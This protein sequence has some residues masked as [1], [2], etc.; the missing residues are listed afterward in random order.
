MIENLHRLSPGCLQEQYDSHLRF[1]S[2]SHAL[3][4]LW[5]KDVSLWPES[6]E[7]SPTSPHNLDWLDLPAMLDGLLARVARAF[8]PATIG[9][10]DQIVF[11]GVHSAS[12]AAELIATVPMT[13]SRTV[14]LMN[15]VDPG[16]I[17]AMESKVDLSR[18]LF[19]VA[20]K[21][22][23]SLQVSLLLLHFLKRF[24]EAGMPFPGSHFM[25]FTES[26]SYLAELAKQY[27][28]RE[29]FV[30]PPGIPTQFSGLIHYNVILAALGT[31]SPEALAAS[32][33]E[34]QKACSPCAPVSAN[35]ALALAAL[36]SAV[37]GQSGRVL[38]CSSPGLAPL[39]DRLSYVIGSAT[40]RRGGGIF[41]ARIG[42]QS[43]PV[44]ANDLS[45][46]LAFADEPSP[47]P[48]AVAAQRLAAGAPTLEIRIGNASQIAAEVFCWEIASCLAA[49][50]IGVNP[51]DESDLAALRSLVHS[52]L[53]I[54]GCMPPT[55]PTPRFSDDSCELYF[56]GVTRRQLSTLSL[57]AALESLIQLIPASGYLALMSFLPHSESAERQLESISTQLQSTLKVPVTLTF[58]TRFLNRI[59]QSLLGGPNIGVV[60]ILTANSAV[61]LQVFGAP[62]TF[63]R[64]KRAYASATLTSL[65]E[66]QLY[67]LRVHLLDDTSV[68][69]AGFSA[70]LLRV[71]ENLAAR[72][73]A[74]HQVAG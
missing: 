22:G 56:E 15:S 9:S 16:A 70:T 53:D 26:N 48:E 74:A 23:S 35:P 3:T 30:D 55:A 21:Q 50:R 40:C 24:K 68:S 61:D 42:G 36:L 69:L 62:Y 59:G 73:S 13:A 27:A 17:R 34:M 18:A 60:L 1:F 33:Q 66:R 12:L 7:Y 20:S 43:L 67:A 38:F 8:A 2:E 57:E 64:L 32:A 51:F 25:V 44:Q 72:G 58:D 11:L 63:G 4:R 47:E 52:D 31:C 5:S 54:S 29:V 10:L 65:S 19:V 37:H 39:A 45:V 6:S 28:F 41:S 14:L 49:S 71:A 46:L